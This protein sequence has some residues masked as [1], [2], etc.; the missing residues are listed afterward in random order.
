[1][2]RPAT[3]NTKQILEVAR[4]LFLTKGPGVTTADLSTLAYRHRRRPLYP[5]EE[6]ARYE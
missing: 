6:N 5:F 2:G 3:I 1:M 4:E